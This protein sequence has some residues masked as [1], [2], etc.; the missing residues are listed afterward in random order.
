[1]MKEGWVRKKIKDICDK[2]SSNIV[3]NKVMDN[4]GDYPLYGA[5]GFVKCVDFY[6]RDEPYI[7][8]VKDGSGVGRVNVYPAYS[9]L[10][11]TMQYVIPKNGFL[12]G[13]IKYVLQSLNL[14]HFASGAAIPHIYFKDYG[15]C[16]VL[17]P[18]LSEQ[19]SI[20][21]ELNLL[22]E[23]LIKKREQLKELERLGQAI[24]YDMFGDPEINPNSYIKCKMEDICVKITDGT[25]NPP[26]FI[27]TGIPFLLVSNIK[28]NEI[29]YE[30]NKYISDED[31]CKLSKLAPVDIGDI[32]YTSV[33]SYG[34][35]AIVK[36]NRKFAFQRHIA[37]LK[38]RLDK[39][40]SIFLHSFLLTPYAKH[41]ANILAIG[42]ALLEEQKRFAFK[43]ERIENQKQK[44]KQS[45][46]EVQQ[47]LDYTMNKYFG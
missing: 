27:S 24:F 32:L 17:I 36:V 33:G 19:E 4:N 45:I 8:I 25:H 13:Y 5:S 37:L 40:I 1:M 35:P 46:V 3:Q 20:V 31:Y 12:L 41:Q 6:H 38:P 10:V 39:V 43:I 44:I 18:P 28:E 47:L 11:G 34:N 26:Q 7:G 9:S 42:V 14:A 16:T 15:E 22:N 29:I 30:T 23:I 2:A 21:A